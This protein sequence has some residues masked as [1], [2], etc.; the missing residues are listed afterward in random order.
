MDL[1][2]AQTPKLQ[3]S[4]TLIMQEL[5]PHHYIFNDEHSNVLLEHTNLQV[6]HTTLKQHHFEE[7]AHHITLIQA[8]DP[9]YAQ[10]PREPPTMIASIP[11]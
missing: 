1:Q 9:L 2:K 5:T 10:F 4:H 11:M 3:D 8:L 6:S 7:V